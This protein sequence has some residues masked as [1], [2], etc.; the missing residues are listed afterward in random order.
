MSSGEAPV[1][2]AC[3][4]AKV[5]YAIIASSKKIQDDPL[6]G[7]V[8]RLLEKDP[9][10]I[11][12]LSQLIEHDIYDKLDPCQKEKYMIKLSKRYVEIREYVIKE[13][14]CKAV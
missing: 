9:D 8:K 12:P 1:S 5:Q 2:E 11:S 7:K 14:M 3:L 6:F 10:T 4:C 13:L